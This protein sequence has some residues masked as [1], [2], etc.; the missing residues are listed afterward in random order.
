[1]LAA[2]AWHRILLALGGALLFAALAGCVNPQVCASN[3]DC[4]AGRFCVPDASE[5]TSVCGAPCA[6]DLGCPAGQACVPRDDGT[7]EG[8]CLALLDNVALGEA[9]TTDRDC[10]SGACEGE[11]APV[12]V[13][14]CTDDLTCQNAEERCILD[15]IRRV[16]VPPTDDLAAGS[17]C[18]DPRQCAS[19]TCVD[20][21]DPSA[22]EPAPPLCADNCEVADDCP[23]DGD[24]CV[25]LL[26]GARA[27]L[28]PL[29]DGL[30]CQASSACAGGFCLED[31]DG[32]LKCASACVD[33]QC[34][35]GFACVD[36]T[37]QHRVCMPKLD[38]R[39]SGEPCT[40]ARE[41]A[42]GHCAHFASE[43]EEYG[44]LCADP[45]AEDG[46]CDGG[47]VCWEDDGGTDVCGPVPNG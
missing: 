34:A 12:C 10:Q 22:E 14:Q 47:L 26:G 2:M 1:M 11:T 23:R 29:E 24:A 41:C 33:E 43:T 15:G 30:P 13:E 4:P 5:G 3:D 42:S 20:P 21:P 8:A 46:T 39:P 19:G 27:C 7:L 28:D 25:R 37:E 16:C 9:C 31:I 36:D 17:L 35:D 38:S 44:T 18:E 6:A 40:T 45:C 32:S